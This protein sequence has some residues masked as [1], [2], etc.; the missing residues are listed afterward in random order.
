MMKIPVWI[1]VILIILALVILGFSVFI[2]VFQN[3]VLN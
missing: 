1:K 2:T 3:P